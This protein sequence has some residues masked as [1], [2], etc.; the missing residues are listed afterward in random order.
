[1]YNFST[2]VGHLGGDATANVLDN[3][4]TLFTFGLATDSYVGDGKKETEWHSIKYFCRSENYANFLR[5]SLKKGSIVLV[6]GE[7]RTD[8][9]MEEGLEQ[10]A[11]RLY[12]DV[13]KV[14]HSAQLDDRQDKAAPTPSSERAPAASTPRPAPSAPPAAPYPSVGQTN[15]AQRTAAPRPAPAPPPAPPSQDPDFV[16]LSTW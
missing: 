7:S 11:K 1:M 6:A 3:G 16:G 5:K 10:R 14:I 12:A 15:Q 9:W 8:K 2:L 13:T 4:T